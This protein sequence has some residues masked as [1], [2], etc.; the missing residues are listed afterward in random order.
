MENK[1]EGVKI[2]QPE[3]EKR[4]PQWC[5]MRDVMEGDDT[6]KAKGETYL[7]RPS[8]AHKK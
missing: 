4:S 5:V 8:S 6:I 3:Y 7:P 2:R 1:E